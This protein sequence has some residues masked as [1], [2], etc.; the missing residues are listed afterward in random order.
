M[1][2][3]SL[4][5]RWMHLLGA[6]TLVGSVIF[7]LRA[8]IPWLCGS[9]DEGRKQAWDAIRPGWARLVMI[10]STALLVSGLLNVFLMAKTGEFKQVA[11]AYHGLLG[12]KILLA[13]IVIFLMS[14]VS[15]R[16]ALAV[17]AREKMTLWI[18][19]AAVLAV[20]TGGLGG[21]LKNIPRTEGDGQV[22]TA[23]EG[24]TIV[25]PEAT[26]G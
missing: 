19:I 1:D 13:L 10:S 21:V 3:L 7:V 16:S 11:P 4:I 24:V 20:L 23:I 12:V 22:D 25:P 9:S 18:A 2:V 8:L 6:A 17:R 26:D 14:V 5:I 15:G